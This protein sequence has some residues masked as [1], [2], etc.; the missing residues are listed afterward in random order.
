MW[1]ISSSYNHIFSR[2]KTKHTTQ[3]YPN[4]GGVENEFLHRLPAVWKANARGLNL[5]NRSFSS[6]LLPSKKKRPRGRWTE[7]TEFEKKKRRR[8]DNGIV[9]RWWTGDESCGRY[10]RENR[11][12]A[13]IRVMRVKYL[14]AMFTFHADE[15]AGE[16]GW[17][18]YRGR[19]WT[20]FLERVDDGDGGGRLGHDQDTSSSRQWVGYR[21]SN[22]MH[23]LRERA[24]RRIRERRSGAADRRNGGCRRADAVVARDVDAEREWSE[25]EE[26]KKKKNVPRDTQEQ[27]KRDALNLRRRRLARLS[28]PAC[29]GG[30]CLMEIASGDQTHNR[31]CG[32]RARTGRSFAEKKNFRFYFFPPNCYIRISYND[33]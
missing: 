28:G 22:I 5:E 24:V 1:T 12:A 14:P 27:W 7:T 21:S 13:R 30:G 10:F 4:G 8:R 2:M 9:G 6:P 25:R 11:P 16:R 18:V 19:R 29:G 31:N 15:C 32:A 3:A 23:R 20:A 26:K 33:Y 17:N